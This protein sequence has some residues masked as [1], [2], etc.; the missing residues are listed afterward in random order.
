[1][2]KPAAAEQTTFVLP[3]PIKLM[4]NISKSLQVAAALAQEMAEQSQSKPVEADDTPF[5]PIEPVLKTLGEVAQTYAQNPE[6]WAEASFQLWQGYTQLWQNAWSRMLGE[7]KEPLIS[8]ARG[9]KRFNDPDWTKNQVFD[10]FKQSYLLTT[11]WAHE[12][13]SNANDIDENTRHKASFYFDQIANALSPSNFAITNPEIL[14]Q[15]L[16]SNGENLLQG[17]TNLARDLKAGNGTLKIKQTDMSAFALGENMALSPGQVI[18]QNEVMQLIQYAPATE[19][20]Y[21]RPLLIVPPWINKF[22]IL[23]L[24]PKK[25]FIRWAVEQGMTVL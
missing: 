7:N 14:K 16:A 10:F 22:Y 25:S 13:I 9:D 8:P 12:T 20:V 5:K 24:N 3:D 11:K 4:D 23:D 21:K 17:M 2:S 1:M 15:T 18:Y 19:K 6:R